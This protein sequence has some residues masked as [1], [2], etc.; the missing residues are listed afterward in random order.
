MRI[1]RP[2]SICAGCGKRLPDEN[3]QWFSGLATSDDGYIRH[4]FCGECIFRFREGL[5]C[6]WRRRRRQTKPLFDR[7]G[8]LL[9]FEELSRRGDDEHALCAMALV[10]LRRHLLKLIEI[11]VVGGRRVMVLRSKRGEFAVPSVP[12]EDAKLVELKEKLGALFEER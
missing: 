6:W 5:F 3:G 7:E 9:F 10:L 12:L 1:G 8:A 4:D 11:R 2:K